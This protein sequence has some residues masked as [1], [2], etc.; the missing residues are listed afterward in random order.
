MR[1]VS[2]VTSMCLFT[3][4]LAGFLLVVFSLEPGM[5]Y[6]EKYH[7]DLSI[8][9]SIPVVATSDG[10]LFC[11]KGSNKFPTKMVLLSTDKDIVWDKSIAY[12]ASDVIASQGGACVLDDRG[13]F[14]GI[15]AAGS[16]TEYLAEV[17][18]PGKNVMAKALTGMYYASG[19]DNSLTCFMPD[20]NIEWMI[21]TNSSPARIFPI[22]QDIIVSSSSGSL[23]RYTTEGAVVWKVDAKG[24]TIIDPI[25]DSEGNLVYALRNSTGSSGLLTLITPGG[26]IIRQTAI[27]FAPVTIYKFDTGYMVVGKLDSAFV[28][29]DGVVAW[30]KK[31]D[32]AA[33]SIQPLGVDNPSNVV[34]GF[35]YD[36]QTAGIISIK[37]MDLAGNLSEVCQFTIG[38]GKEPKLSLSGRSL[39]IGID[40]TVTVYELMTMK[41]Y[42]DRLN[43]KN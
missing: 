34:L 19:G 43:R 10:F 5:K 30:S 4:I 38:K 2:E 31:L 33:K 13:N 6:R 28:G 41:E 14:Y 3:N 8:N 11:S 37:T 29:N 12:P 7:V 27:Q 32:P 9:P 24:F 18:P 40:N 15:D 22:D 35:H 42:I 39:L 1:V 16:V 25:T 20:G 17:V 23:I 26:K 36:N 21:E